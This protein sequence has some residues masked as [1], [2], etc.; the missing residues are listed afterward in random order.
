MGYF[1][2]DYLFVTTYLPILFALTL[3]GEGVYKFA[4]HGFGWVPF[5]TGMVFLSIVIAVRLGSL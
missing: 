1:T 2:S 4:K 5:I 3:I